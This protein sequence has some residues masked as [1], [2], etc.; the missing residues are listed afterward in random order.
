[1][2][3]RWLCTEHAAQSRPVSA[4]DLRDYQREALQ[5]SVRRYEAGSTRLIFPIATG[6]GKTVIFSQ[7]PEAF[8]GLMAKGMIVLVHRE[9]LV[10]QSVA[11]IQRA[12][13][14]STV[15]VEKGDE[16]PH[17]NSLPDIV[18]ASVQT[19]GRQG[20]ARLQ[21]YA[22]FGGIVVVDE[23]HHLAPGNSYDRVLN[24]FGVGSMRGVGPLSTP[25]PTPSPSC[26]SGSGGQRGRPAPNDR[27]PP[28]LAGFTATP[29]RTDG[30]SLAAFFDACVSP[31]SL[32]WGVQQGHLVDVEVVSI[33]T[34][35]SLDGVR[36]R[37]GDFGARSLAAAVNT[38]ERN[39]AVVQAIK[40]HGG[41]AVLAFCASVGH[42]LDMQA[43]LREH[44]I[45]AEAVSAGTEAEA[46]RAAVAAFR[47]AGAAGAA[48]GEGSGEGGCEGDG[49][50]GEEGAGQRVL[51]NYGVFTEGFDAPECDTVVMCRPTRSLVLY[52]QVGTRVAHSAAH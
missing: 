48:G 50:G 31:L 9:E 51:L 52:M 41:R 7:L 42:A 14:G 22:G 36:V 34:S 19:L 29:F 23:A 43:L 44:G 39:A 5:E 20:S 47:Q 16:T 35:V 21:R 38:G 28:L 12:N 45:A 1:M 25:G 33:Q 18:V 49:E 32:V 8:P 2:K 15:G 17:G 37:S 4:V 27:A 26:A 40:D 10:R 13:P 6:L 30:Q 46:R 11:A 3:R 24:F